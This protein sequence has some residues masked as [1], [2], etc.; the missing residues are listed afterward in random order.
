MSGCI[1]ILT[2]HWQSPRWIGIQKDYLDRHLELPNRRYAFLTGIDP[3]YC[4]Y[5][6]YVDP[7]PLGSHAK[8]LNRLA[9]HVCQHAHDNDILLFL[10]GDA[11]PIAPMDQPL[12]R[13]LAEK[14]LVAVQRLENNG[15]PQP[16]PCFCATRVGFWKEIKGDWRAGY[17]WENSSGE[18]ITDV[19]ARLLQ[20]LRTCRQ[21]WKKLNRSNR[22][23]LHPLWFAI[24]GD[25]VY[26]HGAGFR[27]PISRADLARHMGPVDRL[28][29]Q[30]RLKLPNHGP[31]ES[32]RDRFDPI[33]RYSEKISA[34][35]QILADDVYRKIIEDPVFYHRFM[36]PPGH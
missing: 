20:S 16:H 18:L 21:D 10:D 34:A 30:L 2:V 17:R 14:P 24:Y 32:L 15:D 5:F 7:Q 28:L 9:Q 23:D 31:W 4:N 27:A 29:E 25:T 26:H 3:D 36:N 22:Y 33:N 12:E 11:F 19:G 35:N 8:K 6:D 13:W 1:H